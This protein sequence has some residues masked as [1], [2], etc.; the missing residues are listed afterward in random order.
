M[1]SLSLPRPRWNN[2]DTRGAIGG[3]R[4]GFSRSIVAWFAGGGLCGDE[5][6][7]RVREIARNPSSAIRVG[8]VRGNRRDYVYRARRSHDR[9]GARDSR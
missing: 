7:Q 4:V 3:G 2:R 1:G 8:G 6:C 9:E 5:R